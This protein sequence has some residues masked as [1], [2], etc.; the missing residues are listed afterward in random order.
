MG[1]HSNSMLGNQRR[2][3][4]FRKICR[5]SSYSI[6]TRREDPLIFVIRKY[7]NMKI[8]GIWSSAQ[9]K[10]EKVRPYLQLSGF[11]SW[12]YIGVLAES[13]GTMGTMWECPDFFP[14]GERYVLMFSLM[15]MGDRKTIYLTSVIWIT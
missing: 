15:G 8:Y 10:M 7:G 4:D 11:A 1:I 3:R 2:W 9:V 14:L 5:E 12:E 13:D 6:P